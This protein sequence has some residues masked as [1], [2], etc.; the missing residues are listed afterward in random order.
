L[1]SSCKKLA[2][3]ANAKAGNPLQK[4]LTFAAIGNFFSSHWQRQLTAEPAD[5]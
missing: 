1:N 3:A 4:L 2:V 5:K